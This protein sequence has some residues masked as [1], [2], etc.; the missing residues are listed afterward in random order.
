MRKYSYLHH[1]CMLHCL[2]RGKDHSHQCLKKCK[3]NRLNIIN[4]IFTGPADVNVL[5][6][7]FNLFKAIRLANELK[8]CL[9]KL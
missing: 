6:F 2:H 4:I 7:S 3:K 1:L 5:N 8:L 9:L